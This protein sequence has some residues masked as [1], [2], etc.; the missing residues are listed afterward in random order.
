M[1]QPNLSKQSGTIGWQSPSNIAIVKYWGKKD[2]QIPLNPSV[3]MTLS[4]SCTKTVVD[5]R[6]RQ[7]EENQFVFYFNHLPNP[8]FEP[9]I[10][11]FFEHVN[12][13]YP[14]LVDY[15]F[16]ISSSNTFPH[17]T[18]IAS[19]ASSMSALALCVTQI[20]HVI[21]QHNKDFNK[22]EAGPLAR[23][24]SGSACRSLHGGWSLW[25]RYQPLLESSDFQAVSINEQ[26]HPLFLDF[27]DSILVIDDKKKSVSSTAGHH[28]M[29]HHPYAQ[30]RLTQAFTNTQKL[31]SSLQTGDLEQFIS[32]CEEEALSL[33]AL[34]MSSNPGFMLMKPNTLVA[35]EKIR[36]FRLQQN[37]PVCFTLDAGP[38]IHLL[39]PSQYQQ[40]TKQWI[41]RELKPL[42][43][44]RLIIHDKTGNGPQP[45]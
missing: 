23:L 43:S 30:G 1:T 35:I 22:N 17:S 6:L 18:G 29:N 5:Y 16:T 13:L 33:H 37:I 15:H 41:D 39:Y 10:K 14:H 40:I 24:G 11:S 7:M 44:N 3:S 34:M 20:H 28:L 31:L 2:T 38:N 25:G 21:N 12:Q 27:C 45:L 4:E 36:D 26:I 32:V 8:S 19:S 42:C 9:K